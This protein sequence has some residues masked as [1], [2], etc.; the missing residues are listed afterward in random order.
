MKIFLVLFFSVPFHFNLKKTY[1]FFL[2]IEQKYYLFCSTPWIANFFPSLI[3]QQT[4]QKV[5]DSIY[6]NPLCFL[7]LT[8]WFLF[9][10]TPWSLYTKQS[11]VDF[12]LPDLEAFFNVVNW[13]SL[14]VEHC[15]SDYNF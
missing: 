11:S 1:L 13:L 14:L 10:F 4:S 12:L 6:E 3:S 7:P 5:I 9:L 8:I 15:V 2:K